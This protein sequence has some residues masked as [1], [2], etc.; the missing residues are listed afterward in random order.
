MLFFTEF[1]VCNLNVF[2]FL[3]LDKFTREI[4]FIIWNTSSFFVL[5]NPNSAEKGRVV[6]NEYLF[7]KSE[8]QLMY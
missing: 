7:S 5:R 1:L 6:T 3:H 2:L 8:L 4:V